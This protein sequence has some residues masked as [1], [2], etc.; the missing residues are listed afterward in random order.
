MRPPQERPDPPGRLVG[1]AEFQRLRRAGR[2]SRRAPR[3]RRR[4]RR[5]R[6]RP[7][8]E[9]GPRRRSPDASRPGAAPS[10]RSPPRWRS[11]R[12]ARPPASARRRSECRRPLISMVSYLLSISALHANALTPTCA[13]SRFG[14]IASRALARKRAAELGHARQIVDRPEFVDMRQHR[15]Q[16]L[17]LRGESVEAQQRIE[18]DQPAAGLVQ[19][20]HLRR[21]RLEA[22]RSRPSVNS[23]TIAPCPSTRRDQSRLNRCSEAPMR[24]PPDQSG[25]LARA[26]A[27]APRRDRARAASA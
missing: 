14:S 4:P 26:T 12:C 25:D 6:R 22:S 18:P 23:S 2:R 8:R 7:S 27:R 19:A 1:D 10:P 16:A 9:N 21:E 20:L 11:R 17:R 5:S 13:A 15:A 24:V 3:S